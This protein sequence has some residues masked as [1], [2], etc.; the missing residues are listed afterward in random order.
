VAL[1]WASLAGPGAWRLLCDGLQGWSG[2]A[3]GSLFGCLGVGRARE[4]FCTCASSLRPGFLWRYKLVWYLPAFFFQTRTRL[5]PP[6]A[7]FPVGMVSGLWGWRQQELSHF[8]ASVSSIWYPF[9]AFFLIP[10]SRCLLGGFLST[11]FAQGF[12]LGSGGRWRCYQGAVLPGLSFGRL[13]GTLL[14]VPFSCSR[15]SGVRSG[16]WAGPML[17]FGRC[18]VLLYVP[19]VDSSW[20]FLFFFE[21][22]RR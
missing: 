13:D 15:P 10:A 5:P 17:G 8:F 7:R 12:F 4:K 3:C 16:P 19:N 2:V 11:A 18:G 6:N 9:S 22:R 1:E 14:S 20:T 21:L